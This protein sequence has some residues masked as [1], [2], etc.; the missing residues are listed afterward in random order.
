[1]ATREEERPAAERPARRRRRGRNWVPWAV[2]GAAFLIL[3]L[4]LASRDGKQPQ[5]ASL[6]GAT[7]E[8]VVSSLTGMPDKLSS[9]L[10]ARRE[11]IVSEVAGHWRIFDQIEAA[12]RALADLA[13]RERA[14]FEKALSPPPSLPP[15]DRPK[16]QV[17]GQ[18]TPA[19][20]LRMMARQIPEDV[21]R[22]REEG[23]PAERAPSPG[24]APEVS[25]PP[26]SSSLSDRVYALERQGRDDQTHLQSLITGQN[27]LYGLFGELNQGVKAIQGELRRIREE[28]EEAREWREDMDVWR[29]G[30]DDLFKGIEERL[31]ERL[32]QPHIHKPGEPVDTCP[33]KGN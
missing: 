20:S 23:K 24:K 4:W 19:D 3:L 31:E 22:L 9:F 26:P 32:P 17:L 10:A 2:G 25:Q 12:G 28:Q 14:E 18:A 29:E 15:T 11:S 1:M 6:N 27:A 16:E 13:T 5:V 30:V 8:E 7:L 21:K 33:Y